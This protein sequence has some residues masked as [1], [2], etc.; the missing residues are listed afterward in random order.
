MSWYHIRGI[1]TYAA[2]LVTW[3]IIVRAD[4]RFAPSQWEM[5]LLC[6]NIFYWLGAS[7]ESAQIGSGNGLSPVQH[8]VITI[9]NDDLL[10]IGLLSNKL[11]WILNQN[12]HYNCH[13]ENEFESA[14]Y[15]SLH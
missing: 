2:I 6:N 3:I 5:V 9:A 12:T 11:Q 4:S 8:Q 10:S 15:F 13:P 7:L 1:V 14:V